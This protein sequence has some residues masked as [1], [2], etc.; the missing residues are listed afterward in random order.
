METH[1]DSI[2]TFQG[3]T[4]WVSTTWKCMS[5]VVKVTCCVFSPSEESI[6][7]GS[8]DNTLCIWETKSGKRLMTLNGHTSWV[9][10]MFAVHSHIHR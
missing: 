10:A 6:L 5:H 3:H 2:V 7:S 8:W 4:D 9:D 1:D